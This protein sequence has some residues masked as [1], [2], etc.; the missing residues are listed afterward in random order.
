MRT[1][2]IILQILGILLILLGTVRIFASEATFTFFNYS[3]YW[4]SDIFLQYLFRATGGFILFHGFI[5]YNI[6]RELIRFRSLLGPYAF[7]LL[8]VG[9]V[10][11]VIGYLSFL[12]I[13]LYVSDAI[14]CYFIAIFC[15]YIRE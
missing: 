11:L 12:P 6:S 3:E 4:F 15:I 14:I 7:A 1:K 9:S 8:V 10:M 13:W 2:K 5:L